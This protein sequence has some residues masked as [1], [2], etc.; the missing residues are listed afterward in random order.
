MEELDSAL[1]SEG[2]TAQGAYLPYQPLPMLLPS[3]SVRDCDCAQHTSDLGDDQHPLR[4]VRDG[5]AVGCGPAGVASTDATPVGQDSS[6]A[7]HASSHRAGARMDGPCSP[8]DSGMHAHMSARSVT[9]D[10]AAVR[11]AH[12]RRSSHRVRAQYNRTNW[13]GW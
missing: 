3:D 13:N 2:G 11:L 4:D 5:C 1:F 12:L 7:V 8:P 6:Q 10:V 9:A